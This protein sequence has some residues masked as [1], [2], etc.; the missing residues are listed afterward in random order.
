MGF[1]SDSRVYAMNIH[2]TF[3]EE[4]N[5]IETAV[6]QRNRKHSISITQNILRTHRI[7]HVPR[8][9]PDGGPSDGTSDK[10]FPLWTLDPDEIRFKT[11]IELTYVII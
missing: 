7:S 9:P 3:S 6:S 11:R 2:M 5:G 8:I 4:N 10:N 1:D